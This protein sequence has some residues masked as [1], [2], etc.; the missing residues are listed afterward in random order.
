[1]MWIKSD[2]DPSKFQ[3]GVIVARYQIDELHEGHKGVLDLVCKNHSKVIVFLGIPRT[4]P[5]RKNP[6]DFN[7]R[8][9][10]LQAQYPNVVILPIQDKRK[11][12]TWSKNLD[13]LARLPFGPTS[14]LLYGSRDSFI[15]SYT[16]ELPV[17]EVA[18]TVIA[19]AT[20][21]RDKIGK[22]ARNSADFR[23]GIIYGA[24]QKP[25]VTYPT[26]D[27]VPI[28]HKNEI[29]LAKKPDEDLLR[30]VGGFVDTGDSSYE[31]TGK[32]EFLEETGGVIDDL[33]YVT[34]GRVDDWRYRNE[35]DGIMTILFAATFVQGPSQANDDIESLT[36]VPISQLLKANVNGVLKDMIMPEH[37]PFM[38]R[39]LEV[40][41]HRNYFTLNFEV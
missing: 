28:N 7:T 17:A 8:R 18:T 19:D 20:S 10:M 25:P 27:V 29:L 12:E 34:S 41:N 33:R 38:E 3:V 36:W 35:K 31:T 5:T 16:G 23:A 14:I 4:S 1:M 21:I 15:S 30:F 24:Y 26:I 6:L 37:L 13:A 2:I 22:T 40:G 32:R 9:L 39:F 11:N